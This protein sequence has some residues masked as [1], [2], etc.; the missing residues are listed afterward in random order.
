[1]TIAMAMAATCA[2]HHY[3]RQWIMCPSKNLGPKD[4]TKTEVLT[5]KPSQGKFLVDGPKKN[6]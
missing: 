2:H 3:H 4:Q 1:M 5:F 6:V